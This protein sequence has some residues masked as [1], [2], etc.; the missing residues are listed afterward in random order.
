MFT[1]MK[2][3]ILYWLLRVIKTQTLLGKRIRRI[4]YIKLKIMKIIFTKFMKKGH[5]LV[6]TLKDARERGGVFE[7]PFKYQ[8]FRWIQF[9]SSQCP[10]PNR[11]SFFAMKEIFPCCALHLCKHVT[12]ARRH[13]AQFS[14][15]LDSV[16]LQSVRASMH[17]FV[18]C[19]YKD[20]NFSWVD[21]HLLG[22]CTMLCA[23]GYQPFTCFITFFKHSENSLL[24]S[25]VREVSSSS[26]SA[27][28]PWV[29]LGLLVT[30][31]HWVWLSCCC[32]RCGPDEERILDI[33]PGGTELKTQVQ[34]GSQ[35]GRTHSQ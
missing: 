23:D 35:A 5:V 20:M 9:M 29:G 26:S 4:L 27:L 32:I 25:S 30:E 3:N 8:R 1:S 31:G 12:S 15:N 2:N 7:S 16:C 24:S 28:Q 6:E 33:V 13:C 10:P 11:A 14:E 19:P 34:T 22:F 17:A 18:T 21:F